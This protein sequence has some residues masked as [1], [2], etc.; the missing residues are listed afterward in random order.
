MAGGVTGELSVLLELV[1]FICLSVFSPAKECV[2]LHG[3]VC[4][5]EARTKNKPLTDIHISTY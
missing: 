4:V 2:A 1:F 3:S 5:A